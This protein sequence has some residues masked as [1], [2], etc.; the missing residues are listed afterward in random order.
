M[1]DIKFGAASAC[2]VFRPLIDFYRL[3]ADEA[4]WTLVA[5]CDGEYERL[6][7]TGTARLPLNKRGDHLRCSFVDAPNPVELGGR[8]G[9]LKVLQS[10]LRLFGQTPGLV[11]IVGAVT[12]RWTPREPA[13]AEDE[14]SFTI[15]VDLEARMRL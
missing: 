3:E 11:T 14:R 5:A 2:R 4:A 13:C 8:A 9:A 6:L 15:A 12:T 7:L 10:D 1:N